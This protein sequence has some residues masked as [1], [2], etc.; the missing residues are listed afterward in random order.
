M[1]GACTRRRE[2]R[3]TERERE[4][5]RERHTHGKIGGFDVAVEVPE[6]VNSLCPD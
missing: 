5:E 6:F 4:R 3:E 2:K 1:G